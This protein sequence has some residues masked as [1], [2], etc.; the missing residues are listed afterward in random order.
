MAVKSS[1]RSHVLFWSIAVLVILADR[2]TKWLIV[3]YMQLGES[4]RVFPFFSITYVL[5]KGTAFGLLQNGG[6]FFGVFA[7]AVSVYI[8]YS[9][10]KFAASL[11]IILAL[12]LG[13]AVG[14]LIDRIV[15]GPVIDFLNFHVWPVFNIADSAVTVAI[16]LLITRGFMSRN[17]R[18]V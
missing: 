13:G 3:N 12:L 15:Y 7:L 14:N 17:H 9:Y 10:R 2:L 6:W 18:K 5:N 16:I 8:I 11:Q 4:I 1:F